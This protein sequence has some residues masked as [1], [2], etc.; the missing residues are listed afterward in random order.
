[1]GYGFMANQKNSLKEW[2]LLAEGDLTVAEHLINTMFLIPTAAI[3]F[4]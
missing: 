1:M 4:F 3:A 2:R